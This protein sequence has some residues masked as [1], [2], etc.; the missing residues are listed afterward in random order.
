MFRIEDPQGTE[1][2]EHAA[3][4]PR[5][6]KVA[7]DIYREAFPEVYPYVELFFSTRRDGTII[8]AVDDGRATWDSG[9]SITRE[10]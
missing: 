5:A 7:K 3:K 8:L 2:V 9:I 4:L 6:K 1:R 10:R